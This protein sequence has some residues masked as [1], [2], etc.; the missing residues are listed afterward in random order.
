MHRLGKG[1]LCG[2]GISSVL[3]SRAQRS[4]IPFVEPISRDGKMT[5]TRWHGDLE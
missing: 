4:L 1:A 3:V 5:R 2:E